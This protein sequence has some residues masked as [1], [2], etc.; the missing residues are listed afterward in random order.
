V[1]ISVIIPAFNEEKL[2]PA[3]LRAIQE[4][5][6]AFADRGWASELIVCDNNSTDHTSEIAA[7]GGARVVFEPINQIGRARNTGAAVATGDW[8]LFID[9]DSRP[10]AGLFGAAAE[11]MASGTCLAGGSTI[12]LDG[13][14]RLAQATAG[15][16]NW[17]SVRRQLLA[18]SFIF[19]QTV[20]FHELGGFSAELFASEELDLTWR[21]KR[22]A[23]GRGQRLVILQG[24]PL[25]TSDRKVHLYS[26]WEYFRLL[27]RVV[28]GWGRPLRSRA[29]C[30]HWYDGRR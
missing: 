30:H 16:W 17:L 4:A 7:V 12:R 10:T 19:C 11:A 28:F 13:E 21:L 6:R 24:H 1:K 8:V 3:T 27:A 5:R 14:H 23:A 25:E 18:G 9:A 26:R 2:L 22:L 20:A 15:L 29:A